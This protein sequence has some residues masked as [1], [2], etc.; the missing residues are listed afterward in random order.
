MSNQEKGWSAHLRSCGTYT[1]F[2]VFTSCAGYA[3]TRPSRDH[4][5]SKCNRSKGRHTAGARLRLRRLTGTTRWNRGN[6]IVI[7]F[8]SQELKSNSR[9]LTRRGGRVRW[10]PIKSF[11]RNIT[12]WFKK[13]TRCYEHIINLS[14]IL[15]RTKHT[16]SSK[17]SELIVCLAL[18]IEFSK[19]T[20][21]KPSPMM[22]QWRRPALYSM[23]RYIY[24]YIYHRRP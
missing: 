7:T 1:T 5:R 8:G 11:S 16:L 19:I 3:R 14:Y 20:T 24:I 18:N 13:R 15:F 17:A 10:A 9:D 23:H 6:L 2:Q 12:W 21:L 22:S 4:V